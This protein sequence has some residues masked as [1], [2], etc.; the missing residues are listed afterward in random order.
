MDE[1]EGM[2]PV[3]K[4]KHVRKHTYLRAWR[5]SKK[6]SL[7]AA[8]DRIGVEGTTLGR[9]ERGESPYNQ[10]LLERLA[11]AYGCEPEDLLSVNPLQA[12]PPHL[13]W[14]QLQKAPADV[15]DRAYAVIEALLKA[16]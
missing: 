5:K 14:Q 6:L 12:E 16:G 10:D 13:V 11:L 7:T 4:P 3:A 2:P 9:I 8:G 1:N 15:R